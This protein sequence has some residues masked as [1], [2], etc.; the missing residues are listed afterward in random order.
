MLLR[1]IVVRMPLTDC[2]GADVKRLTFHIRHLSLP[3]SET[4]IRASISQSVQVIFGQIL[5]YDKKEIF[6]QD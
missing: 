2:T 4:G 3:R 5:S 1:H 6:W